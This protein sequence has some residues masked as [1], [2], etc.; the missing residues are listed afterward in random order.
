MLKFSRLESLFFARSRYRISDRFL[1]VQRAASSSANN[2]WS[3]KVSKAKTVSEASSI[4]LKSLQSHARDESTLNKPLRAPHGPLTS[5]VKRAI[6]EGELGEAIKRVQLAWGMSSDSSLSILTEVHAT[7]I[8]AL[9]EGLS[10]RQANGSSGLSS[11]KRSDAALYLVRWFQDYNVSHSTAKLPP[12]LPP[13][14]SKASVFNLLLR[15]F[16]EHGLPRDSLVDGLGT[17]FGDSNRLTSQHVA[18]LGPKSIRVL[19]GVEKDLGRS[20]I[21]AA[22]E[23]SLPSVR[24]AAAS[25]R[26]YEPLAERAYLWQARDG[27]WLRERGYI[28]PGVRLKDVTADVLNSGE[29]TRAPAVDSEAIIKQA[30]NNLGLA[31]AKASSLSRGETDSRSAGHE[32]VDLRPIDFTP[33]VDIPEG[34]S[35]SIRL[36]ASLLREMVGCSIRPNG[37]LHTPRKWV[38]RDALP[39]G[40]TVAAALRLC[41]NPIDFRHVIDMAEATQTLISGPALLIGVKIAM[42]RL[43]CEKT[44]R[45]LLTR[46]ESIEKSIMAVRLDKQVKRTKKPKDELEKAFSKSKRESFKEAYADAREELISNLFKVRKSRVRGEGIG[47]SAASSSILNEVLDSLR[48]NQAPSEKLIASALRLYADL[49][50][51][52]NVT[53]LAL[54]ILGARSLRLKLAQSPSSSPSTINTLLSSTVDK[55]VVKAGNPFSFKADVKELSRL[56]AASVA[57]QLSSPLPLLVSPSLQTSGLDLSTISAA[58]PINF[59]LSTIGMKKINY[60]DSSRVGGPSSKLVAAAVNAL[61]RV[62]FSPFAASI[63]S[64]SFLAEAAHKTESRCSLGSEAT[65]S[66]RLLESYV[67]SLAL[68]GHLD[69]AVVVSRAGL[70]MGASLREPTALAVVRNVLT[71]DELPY[72]FSALRILIDSGKQA[73]DRTQEALMDL[74]SR[75]SRTALPVP[76]AV[77]EAIGSQTVNTENNTEKEDKRRRLA[78]D[79]TSIGQLSQIN[80]SRISAFTDPSLASAVVGSLKGGDQQ[81]DVPFDGQNESNTVV[82]HKEQLHPLVM[83]VTTSRSLATAIVRLIAQQL[84]LMAD[85][86]KAVVAITGK[87]KKEDDEG[88]G[89][90][91]TSLDPLQHASIVDEDQR[92]EEDALDVA[93]EMLLLCLMEWP[94]SER[95]NE[96]RLELDSETA[97]RAALKLKRLSAQAVTLSSATQTRTATIS[98]PRLSNASSLPLFQMLEGNESEKQ[99]SSDFKSSF[100]TPAEEAVLFEKRPI[101]PVVAPAL[102]SL[103]YYALGTSRSIRPPHDPHSATMEDL[104]VALRSAAARARARVAKRAEKRE[105]GAAVAKWDVLLTKIDT[106]ISKLRNGKVAIKLLPPTAGRSLA[107]SVSIIAV[108]SKV[109]EGKNSKKLVKQI[110]V[111]PSSSKNISVLT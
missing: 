101:P 51:Q 17:L 5:F 92:D 20:A 100:D 85:Q 68:L 21:L 111:T 71:L 46:A 18:E 15:V 42:S 49:D 36:I 61:G 10:Q 59:S 97:P 34:C 47:T 32:V 35:R 108:A 64:V 72:A 57:T 105:G 91:E 94:V 33:L 86:R 96:L 43:Q 39:N 73:S 4:F 24:R 11:E 56:Y 99:I 41:E 81:Q 37:I 12:G 3:S 45:L 27:F 13:V 80:T 48:G 19:W 89:V 87:E 90:G 104:T 110:S 6:R 55:D 66:S 44:A 106:I 14:T 102:A 77:A 69:S 7:T 65:M 53:S 84:Q 62:S 30:V 93:C 26:T 109:L 83:A 79:S 28:P 16:N 52:E 22:E 54:A 1:F 82:N 31:V 8:L 67:K 2:D 9:L 103:D 40:E 60:K 75:L 70:V 29:N 95:M 107:K 74:V 78:N 58:R 98:K 23:R 63:I 76:N 38:P 50:D 25:G 88:N